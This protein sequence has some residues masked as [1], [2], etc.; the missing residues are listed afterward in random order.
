M[1]SDEGKTVGS[2]PEAPVVEEEESGSVSRFS[3]VRRKGLVGAT[4]AKISESGESCVYTKNQAWKSSAETLAA[5]PDKGI[6]MGN[7]CSYKYL[8]N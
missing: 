8:F 5:E 7:H 2:R 4:V 1:G 6:P 3:H